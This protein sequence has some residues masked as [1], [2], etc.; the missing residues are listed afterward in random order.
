ML[1][2][3]KAAPGPPPIG[4]SVAKKIMLFGLV[5]EFRPREN[6]SV[7]TPPFTQ[8]ESP[9]PSCSLAFTVGWPRK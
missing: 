1:P 8:D 2:P 3:N 6:L 5:M 4:K 7:A 9:V